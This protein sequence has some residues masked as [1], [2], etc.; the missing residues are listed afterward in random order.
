MNTFFSDSSSMFRP[1][2]VFQRRRDQ[3]FIWAT[4]IAVFFSAF[5]L[6]WIALEIGIQSLPA[7]DRFGLSFFWNTT[8]DPV[9]DIYGAWP[10]IY[11]TLVTSLIALIVGVPFSFGISIFL[12]EDFLPKSLRLAL[13][14]VVELLAAI[15]SV[16]FGIWGLFVF[17]PFF[18][19]VQMFLYE[20][21]NWLPI[22]ST[23]PIGP[24]MLTA[25]VVLG[26]MIIPIITAIAREVLVAV[27][28]EL[29]AAAYAMGATRWEAIF[30]V[31][32]PAAIGG[33]LGAVVLGLGRA[34]GETMAV[35]MLIGN[36]RG[37][38]VSLLAPASNIPALLASEF[39]EAADEQISA[40]M[41]AALIL[42][43][44]T[45]VVNII[46]ELMVRRVKFALTASRE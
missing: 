14:I 19:P 37:I 36:A 7:I 13:I 24:G 26:I 45:L 34:L 35:A 21:F 28:P 39:A 30:G 5:L 43:V 42:L 22:F 25:G 17:I 10:Q 3:V 9:E 27:P 41:Y 1:R 16:V 4:R 18:R 6:L 32:L 12:S 15:P 38:R 29:R 31:V 20:N 40:L 33:M 46:A 11:G 2:P 23:P 44:I 8:W